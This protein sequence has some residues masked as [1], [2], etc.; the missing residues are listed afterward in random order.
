M[1]EL[2]CIVSCTV[3]RYTGQRDVDDAAGVP[4]GQDE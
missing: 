2:H 4:E 3:H 1:L